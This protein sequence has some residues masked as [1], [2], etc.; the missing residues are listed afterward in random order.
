MLTVSLAEGREEPVSPD[1][2]GRHGGETARGEGRD[3]KKGFRSR[4]R[5]SGGAPTVQ[6]KSYEKGITQ[7]R[8]GR[9]G[10]VA[11]KWATNKFP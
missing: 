4:W 6:R 2:D 3:R 7:C 1:A 9:M 5:G 8:M 10:E 11:G